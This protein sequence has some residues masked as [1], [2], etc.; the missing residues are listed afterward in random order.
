MNESKFVFCGRGTR[1]KATVVVVACGITIDKDM[2]NKEPVLSTTKKLFW[3]TAPALKRHDQL[4]SINNYAYPFGVGESDDNTYAFIVFADILRKRNA[5]AR[6]VSDL[7][8]G[9]A[10]K[11]P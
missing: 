11:G 4:L 2:V 9:Y 7:H 1:V 10:P 8:P 6:V 5:F 3:Y